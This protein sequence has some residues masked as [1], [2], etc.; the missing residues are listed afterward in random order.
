VLR[1]DQETKDQVNI[2]SVNTTYFEGRVM[3]LQIVFRTP[4]FVS[5]FK[6]T[7]SLQISFTNSSY[8]RSVENVEMRHNFTL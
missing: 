8:F 5:A 7:D 2:V 4:E 1:Y 6:N 3:K